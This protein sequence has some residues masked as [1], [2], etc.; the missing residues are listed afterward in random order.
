MYWSRPRFGLVM[1]YRTA[2]YDRTREKDSYP[3]H[4]SDVA[5]TPPQPQPNR[6]IYV[7]FS[8]VTDCPLPTCHPSFSLIL[9]NFRKLQLPFCMLQ[10][11]VHL[12]R[13]HKNR[14]IKGYITLY[15]DTGGETQIW[16]RCYLLWGDYRTIFRQFKPRLWVN[17]Q[18]DESRP[19]IETETR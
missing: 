6:Q 19:W 9:Q 12:L 2:P 18:I 8:T 16:S 11:K 13:L 5:P 14:P 10:I 3:H 15:K 7:H 4:S 17:R 1:L